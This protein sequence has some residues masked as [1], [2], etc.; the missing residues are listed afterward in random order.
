MIRSP[1]VED[2]VLTAIA[3]LMVAAMLYAF[4]VA[5]RFKYTFEPEHLLLRWYL[6]GGLRFGT[7]RIPYARIEGVRPIS[8]RLD[9]WGVGESWGNVFSRKGRVLVLSPSFFRRGPLRKVW[10]TPDDPEAFAA[11]LRRH[12]VG[13]ADGA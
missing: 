8:S 12:G 10:I 4:H 13:G 1:G 2:W 3:V 5:S 9:L 6:P 11:E 7:R